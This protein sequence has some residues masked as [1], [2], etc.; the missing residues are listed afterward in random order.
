MIIQ[1][2]D[3]LKQ[4]DVTGVGLLIGKGN[5]KVLLAK[6][7]ARLD[8]IPVDYAVDT[9]LCAAWH[10]TIHGDRDIKVYN[11]TSNADPFR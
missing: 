9:I 2:N 8:L 10:I 3:F 11:C 5:V 6:K 4:F 1:N 7:D